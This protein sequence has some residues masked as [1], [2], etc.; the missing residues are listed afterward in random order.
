MS[1]CLISTEKL[2]DHTALARWSF[3]RHGGGAEKQFEYSVRAFSHM[4]GRVTVYCND[5]RGSPEEL[6]S[7]VTVRNLFCPQDSFVEKL[8]KALQIDPPDYLHASEMVPGAASIRIGDGIHAQF[9]KNMRTYDNGLNCLRFHPWLHRRKL[10]LE[11][12]TLSHPS[13]SHIVSPSQMCIDD[14]HKNIELLGSNSA[15]IPNVIAPEL[16]DSPL[17][18]RK[19]SCILHIIFVGSGYRRKGL[20]ILLRALA[21]VDRQFTLRVVGKDPHQSRYQNLARHLGIEQN[22][23]WLGLLR[24]PIRIYRD[25][26]LL[27]LP[28]LYEPA[29]NVVLEA[30]AMGVKVLVSEFV[31]F[32]SFVSSETG[33]VVSLNEREVAASIEQFVPSLNRQPIRD[34][35]THLNEAHFQDS[36]LRFYR[37]VV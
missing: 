24:D 5:Y 19:D 11:R 3:V 9:L 34:S 35:V 26:D 32:K 23:F 21:L 27:A 15:V 16:I 29:G 31:G 17:S 30:L 20:E 25:A 33:L 14:I 2:W 13:L 6:G 22:V 18:T 28:A 7:N 4:A 12:N 8:H 37:G 10:N 36:L 1:T